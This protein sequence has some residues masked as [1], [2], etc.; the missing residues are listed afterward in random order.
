LQED[1][2][3]ASGLESKQGRGLSAGEKDQAVKQILSGEQVE[4]SLNRIAHEILERTT[5]VDELALVG[6]KKGGVPIAQ[7][8]Q[9]LLNEN[10]NFFIALGKLDISLFRDDVYLKPF[11]EIL[12]SEIPFEINEKT[13]VLIDDV[14][15]TGRSVRAA[16]D[17]LL[18]LGRPKRIWLAV[19]VDRGHR[20]L[21]IR[22]DFVGKNLP[23]SKEE[24]IEASLDGVFLRRE[25]HKNA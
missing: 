24:L 23:T 10:S 11:Q 6:L 25:S 13:I 8:L 19:L 12:G 7:K 3:S 1:K 4:R 15:Y 5:K 18:A 16:L 17:A 2:K 14:I 22:P 9:S 21:P 20:E